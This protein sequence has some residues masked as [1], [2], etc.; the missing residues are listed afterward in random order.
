VS[1]PNGY[2]LL[3]REVRS[4]YCGYSPRLQ[5]WQHGPA[6]LRA[7]RGPLWAVAIPC[8]RSRSGLFALSQPPRLNTEGLGVAG[9]SRNYPKSGDLVVVNG[10]TA[11]PYSVAS[12][13]ADSMLGHE[14]PSLTLTTYADLF[15]SDLDALADVLDQHRTAALQ[16]SIA[17]S[18]SETDGENVPG[19]L[20]QSAQQ[21]CRA[22]Y[23][24]KRG[25]G[26]GIRTHGLFVPNEAR[27]QAA[28]HPA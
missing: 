18:D 24:P 14:D 4:R 22:C 2:A 16:P 7:M 1:L 20:P 26:G 19:T 11:T 6:G 27:Y 28:P 3:P 8:W 5:R 15:D 9:P 12:A 25:R 21:A 23:Q 10:L 17:K 13:V